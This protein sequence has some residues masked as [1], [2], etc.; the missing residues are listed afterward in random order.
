[1]TVDRPRTPQQDRD[2][3]LEILDALD[4]NIEAYN[5][6]RSA[7]WM[8]VSAQLFILLCD[9]N[10]RNRWTALVERAIPTFALHPL[11]NDLS[12]KAHQYLLYIPKI[13]FN[14]QNLRLELFNLNEPRIPLADWLRQVIA[15]LPVNETGVPITLEGLI[16]E[17]RHQAGGGHFDPNV[18]ETLQAAESFIFVEGGAHLPFFS[19]SLAAI[20]EYVSD[21][22]RS[23]MQTT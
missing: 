13:N 23:Q 10:R 4:I 6:G 15:I 22:I 20:G 5:Q 8:A 14:S 9:R 7:G 17:S 19:K 21:E 2:H 1:M 12:G 18:R 16:T 3:L 11:L